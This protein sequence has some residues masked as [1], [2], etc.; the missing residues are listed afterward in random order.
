MSVH[1]FKITKQLFFRKEKKANFESSMLYFITIN[2]YQFTIELY[3][4]VIRPAINFPAH[5]ISYD[6]AARIPSFKDAV[7]IFCDIERFPPDKLSIPR[8][9]YNHVAAQQPRRVLNNP[10]K[11]LQRFE[12]LKSLQQAGINSFNIHRAPLNGQELRYP[13][14]IRNE[15]D[16]CGPVSKLID[17][18]TELQN[19]LKTA[20]PIKPAPFKP[21]IV[22]YCDARST[23]GRYHKYGAFYLW[24]TVVPRHLF[25][26]NHWMVKGTTDQLP[27]DAGKE[28]DYISNNHFAEQLAAAFRIA[29]IEYGRADFVATPRGIEVFEIN[30]NPTV[31]DRG[32]L[33]SNRTHITEAFVVTF[34]EAL[35]KLYDNNL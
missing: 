9:L 34:T 32:D 8:D 30:T 6:E 11:V 35:Q 3:L 7:V 12:L 13:V 31:L 10:W 19:Q 14:F 24:N 20:K 26:S 27:E 21:M 16:H 15:L 4:E 17:N 2:G 28:N 33:N 5:V 18:E 25:F 29:N 22:E 1:L 23:H